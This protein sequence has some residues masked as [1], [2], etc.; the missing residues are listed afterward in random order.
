MA[1]LGG[2]VAGVAHE[3]NTP[4]GVCVTAASFLDDKA[5]EFAKMFKLGRL[6]DKDYVKYIDLSL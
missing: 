2:L 5:K 6:K 4:V 3:V 1:A